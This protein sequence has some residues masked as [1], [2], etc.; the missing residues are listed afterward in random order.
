MASNDDK[1][2]HE[3]IYRYRRA[4]EETLDQVRWCID[5]LYR[6]RKDR[7]AAAVEKNYRLIRRRMTH[8]DDDY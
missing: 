6:I 3:E 7:I 2:A 1:R 4:A 8:P 5:Y